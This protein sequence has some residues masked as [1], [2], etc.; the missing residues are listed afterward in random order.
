VSTPFITAAR[1]PLRGFRI[2]TLDDSREWFPNILPRLQALLQPSD[3]VF[4]SLLRRPALLCGLLWRDPTALGGSL[5]AVP[6]KRVRAREEVGTSVAEVDHK[7][8]RLREITMILE[9]LN[10][11]E[12]CVRAETTLNRLDGPMCEVGL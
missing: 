6:H 11:L 5:P 9:L 12:L 2:S 1:A 4:M 7:G 3:E 8:V 10:V